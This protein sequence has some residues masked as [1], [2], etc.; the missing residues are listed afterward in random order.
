MNIPMLT[1]AL[2]FPSP[3]RASP[4]GI[5]A[6]GGE[7]SPERLLLS[8]SIGIFPWPHRDL[9]LL[10]FSPDPRFVID[11]AR[12]HVPGSLRK[13]MRRGGY[14]IRTDT[15]FREVML[16]CC[17][18]PRPGQDGTWITPAMVAGYTDL[19]R[20][21]FAHSIEAWQ[22]GRLVGGLY[23]ISLG[24]VFFGESMYADVP[25]ASKVA[26][27][28]LLANLKR[29]DFALVDCQS[30]TEHLARF[31]AVDWPRS[32][33]LRVL[34]KALEAPTRRGPWVLEVGTDL[35]LET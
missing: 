19:H 13:R 16:G 12:A 8:Y 11:P 5:V 21:G 4:E 27:A 24:A 20:Q 10:W 32:R 6:F 30:Y 2:A 23:G 18:A 26:F 35:P 22:D 14:E 7:P 25:D 28:T 1:H 34:K 15:C 29:W 9:P 33:F 17:A 3:E 31:G